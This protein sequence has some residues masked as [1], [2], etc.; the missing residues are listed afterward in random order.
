[1]KKIL[2]M[3]YREKVRWKVRLLWLLIV[4]ML[5]YIV[6][7]GETGGGDSRIQTKWADQFGRI[8]L[9]GGLGVVIWRLVHHKRVLKDKLLMKQEAMK[10][11]DEREQYL[12]DKSGGVVVDVLLVCLLFMALTASFYNMPAFHTAYAALLLTAGLKAAAWLFYNR[13]T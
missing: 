3:P 13:V 8:V 5:A 1:M 2:D 7:I 12:H 11:R 10:S 9:F 4:L 6:V